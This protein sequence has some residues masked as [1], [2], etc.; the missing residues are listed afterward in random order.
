M[1]SIIEWNFPYPPYMVY[2]PTFTIK[3]NHENVGKYTVRPMDGS[4]VFVWTVEQTP[5]L[6]LVG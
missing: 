1:A 6:K 5:A 2:L 3:I 4:W